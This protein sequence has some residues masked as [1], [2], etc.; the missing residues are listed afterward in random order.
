MCFPPNSHPYRVVLETVGISSW[1]TQNFDAFF[2][3]VCMSRNSR[4]GQT[5]LRKQS[6]SP[7]FETKSMDVKLSTEHLDEMLQSMFL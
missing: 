5:V 6:C 1:N 2:V 4:A 3:Q 7:A